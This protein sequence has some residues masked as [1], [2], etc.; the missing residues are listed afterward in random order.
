MPSFGAAGFAAPFLQVLTMA[1]NK[2]F[3]CVGALA[4]AHGVKGEVRVR[5]FTLVP[6]DCFAYG[7]L[8]DETGKVALEPETARPAKN[9]FVV[10]AAG[11][12]TRED[13]EALKGTKLYVP[14]DVLPEPEEDEFYYDDLLGLRVTHMDGR[15]LGKVKSV[16]NFGAD[17]L[18]ELVAPDGRTAYFLPFTKAVVPVVRLA[19]KELL[20]EP[21]EQYLPESMQRPDTASDD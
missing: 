16:Q 4:G 5:S 12:R 11:N 21:D 3:I 18:L 20:A 10:E 9:H 19:E 7:P 14:R 15:P 6:E 2:D 1:K 13:W 17:D 8:L